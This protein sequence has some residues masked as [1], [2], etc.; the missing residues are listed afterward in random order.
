MK[1]PELKTLP[2]QEEVDAL[3]VQVEHYK[4]IARQYTQLAAKGIYYTLD[5][6]QAHDAEIKAQ[7]IAEFAD[8]VISHFEGCNYNLTRQTLKCYLHEQLRQQAKLGGL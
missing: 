5:E 7:A 4:E 3:N 1:F 2:T 8:E 6:I